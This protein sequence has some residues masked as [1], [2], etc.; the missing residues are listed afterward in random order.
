MAAFKALLFATK[1]ISVYNSAFISGFQGTDPICSVAIFCALSNCLQS[2][3]QSK[4]AAF[5][6][7]KTGLSPHNVN[8]L[9]F[10]MSSYL[11][12]DHTLETD[13]NYERLCLDRL[14]I[15]KCWMILLNTLENF[16][17]PDIEKLNISNC[18]STS[19][20]PRLSAAL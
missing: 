5:C 16:V 17:P 1:Y 13:T 8:I 14:I 15:D 12:N 9:L 7:T 19:L 2:N 11:H 10:T 4:I 6:L 3:S 20:R 18:C